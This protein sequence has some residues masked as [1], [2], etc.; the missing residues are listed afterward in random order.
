MTLPRPL[1]VVF[2]AL[3]L[4]VSFAAPAEDVLETAYDESELLPYENTSVLSIRL[5]NAEAPPRPTRVPP[6]RLGP[7]TKLRT[8]R[9]NHG[10]GWA[11]PICD[12]LT[13]LNHSRR[14]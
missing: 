3:A 1:C 6:L 10:N 11:C 5:A 9:I 14:C 2:V 8:Q 7:Q 4:S 13:I 12:S